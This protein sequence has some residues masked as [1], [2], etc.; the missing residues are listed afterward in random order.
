MQIVVAG[1]HGLLGGALAARLRQ[2]GHSVSVL[3][4]TARRAGDVAWDPASNDPAWHR[5]VAGADAVVNL[6]GESIAG[7]RWSASRKVAI[8]ESRVR[9]TRA[10]VH[11]MRDAGQRPG[12]FISSSAVGI[13]GPHGDEPLTEDTPPG[14]DFLSHVCEA[15]E[16]EAQGA[17]S[18]TRLVV[19][20]TGVVLARQGGALPQ[21]ALPFRFFAGG[22][23]G[24]GRQFVS[25]IHLEDWVELARWALTTAAVTGPVNVTA[26]A[27]VTNGQFA[28]ALG[29]VLGRPALI[30]APAFALRIALG[31]MADAVLCGQR[32][33]PARAQ[34]LGFRF[35]Y[36]NLDAA[37]RSL[38]P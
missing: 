30:P 24:T 35:G 31:E 13:Y 8:L 33:L 11:A 2:D 6:A 12:V 29:R 19:L 26:P 15:W 36:P 28:E 14:T 18:F 20:R 17:A 27:P 5:V 38:Y 37:L 3:T 23:I 22:R 16:R 4:R 9:A 21:M 25:W 1:G 10:L 34:A 32:V 7:H